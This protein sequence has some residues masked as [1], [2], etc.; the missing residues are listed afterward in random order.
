MFKQT[1]IANS[2]YLNNEKLICLQTVFE[3]HPKMLDLNPSNFYLWKLKNSIV[4]SFN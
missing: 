3:V 4:F 1:S 2:L